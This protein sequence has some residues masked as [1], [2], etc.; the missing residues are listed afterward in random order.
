MSVT[1]RFA[2]LTLLKSKM[3]RRMQLLGGFR[4][5]ISY[6]NAPVILEGPLARLSNDALLFLRLDLP[7]EAEIIAIARRIVR[8]LPQVG[9]RESWRTCFTPLSATRINR[10]AIRSGLQ[11]LS[12]SYLWPGREDLNGFDRV[13]FRKR[14]TQ[15]VGTQCYFF[16][17]KISCANCIYLYTIKLRL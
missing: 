15:K 13:G 3:R 12:R 17:E 11:T 5:L 1:S 4:A 9:S 16:V 8:F 6:I 10:S 2:F 7:R 14:K